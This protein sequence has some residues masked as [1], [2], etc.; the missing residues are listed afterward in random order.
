MVDPDTESEDE[1]PTNKSQFLPASSG[2]NKLSNSASSNNNTNTQDSAQDATNNQGQNLPDIASAMI[3][4]VRAL[5]HDSKNPRGWTILIKFALA[6]LR[7]EH[8][9]DSNIPRPTEGH[10]KY[11]RW[12]YWSRTVASW[13]YLQV[14]DTIQERIQNLVYIPRYADTIFDEIMTIVQGSNTAE[15][16]LNETKKFDKMR[17]SDFNTAKEYIA[18][19]QRQYHVLARFKIAPHPFHALCQVLHQLEKEI[20]KVQFIIEEIGNTEP[21]K[22][23]LEKMDQYCK[24]LQTVA[25]RD[26][27]N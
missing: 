16:A 2:I 24:S 21:K 10:P 23:T 5:E 4:K 17:R 12:R 11:E 19:Y 18:E 9:I 3:Q 14:D 1:N 7:L 22:I 6:P 26:D 20:P 25:D 27:R 13:L 8:V 15:N